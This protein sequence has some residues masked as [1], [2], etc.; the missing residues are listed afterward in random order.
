MPELRS[1]RGRADRRPNVAGSDGNQSLDLND[2]QTDDIGELPLQHQTQCRCGDLRNQRFC[3]HQK[4]GATFLVGQ[5]DLRR[6]RV[7]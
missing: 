4:P 1:S 5:I 6:K 7:K 2:A 3:Q